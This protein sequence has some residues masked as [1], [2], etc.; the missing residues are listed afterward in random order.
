MQLDLSNDQA[1]LL[2][3]VLDSTY[4]DLRMEIAD[5]D[6][7][8]FKHALRDRESALRDLL[9]RLGGPLIP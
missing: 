9:D 5:T 6:N 4:R 8:D 7:P 2:R 1:T 3:E